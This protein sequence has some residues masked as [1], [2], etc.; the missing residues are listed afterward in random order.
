[1]TEAKLHE[2]S[3]L[4]LRALLDDREISSVEI[5]KIFLERIAERNPVLNAFV[6]VTPE[7]ALR[8]AEAADKRIADAKDVRPLTGIPVAIKET[9]LTEGV[10][11][12]AG[13]QFLKSFIPPYNATVTARLIDAGAVMVGKA[14]CDEFAMG[15]S[16]ENSS[17]GNVKNP[18]N[19]KCVPGGS[20]GG[21]AAAVAA[22][23]VPV[24]LGTD[25]GGSI[26]QPAALCGLVGL[27]PTYG[28]VSRY[29]VI[30]FASSLDQV[31]PLAKTVRDA[32]RLYE[33]IA[34]PDASDSTCSTMPLGDLSSCFEKD[35][36]GLRIGYP[37]EYLPEGM[38]KEVR[39]NFF[40][41]MKTLE[42]LGARVEEI[43]L[44]HTEYAIA[45][46]YIVATAE[47]SS[48]LARYDGVRYTS[49]AGDAK[50]LRDLYTKSRS[51]GFGAE[52]QRRILLGTFVLSSGYYDAYYRKAQQVRTLIRA[53]FDK[54]F[55]SVD[56]IATPTSPTP[57]FELG[58]KT[59]NPL[60]MYLSDI[61]TV[62]VSLAGLPGL[63][64]PS[65][66]VPSGLPLG[67]QLV[68][69]PSDEAMLFRLGHFYEQETRYFTRRPPD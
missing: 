38:S 24:A 65:G 48:N 39:E 50:S 61:F 41:A 20:S 68:G 60:D 36:K 67:L 52:V 2:A 13:S 29:G 15:S 5:T 17:F 44:P 27:K 33:T 64:V 47:A 49:R 30:A 10:R 22:R 53:D 45:T 35:L 62:S 56:A 1:M 51:E 46:Y 55:A 8:Q 25:T 43:S 7:L 58:S 23:L 69:N 18:W 11:T 26:R 19:L 31:G 54:A 59:T 57:A 66:F 6:T 63:N 14:N 16:N 37:K 12:T 9:I 42:K 34:G 40:A 28:R 21:S 3:V 4:E 32:A